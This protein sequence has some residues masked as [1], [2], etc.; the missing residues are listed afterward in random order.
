[1]AFWIAAVRAAMN[2][3]WEL[4]MSLPSIRHEARSVSRSHGPAGRGP[5]Q[6]QGLALAD[7]QGEGG[8][9]DVAEL[10]FTAHHHAVRIP[11]DL[12]RDLLALH[13]DLLEPAGA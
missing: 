12:H 1:M 4:W 6:I 2:S 7:A 9:G 8:C 13:V 11:R 3:S 10:G 5:G